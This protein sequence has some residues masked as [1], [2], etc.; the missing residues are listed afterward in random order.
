MMSWVSRVSESFLYGLA[1]EIANPRE[2]S[3]A[4]LIPGMHRG[5]YMLPLKTG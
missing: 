1:T 4:L 5:M 3:Y 2:G